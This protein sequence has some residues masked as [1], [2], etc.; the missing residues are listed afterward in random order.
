MKV[1]FCNLVNIW[2][3]YFDIDKDISLIKHKN[4]DESD[5]SVIIEQKHHFKTD[6]DNEKRAKARKQLSDVSDFK[7]ASDFITSKINAH[8]SY[9][10]TFIQ[11]QMQKW[12]TLKEKRN[13]ESELVDS[14]KTLEK[15]RDEASKAEEYD[16][17]EQ[18]QDKITK[19]VQKI[20]SIHRLTLN[21]E[22]QR[23]DLEN[24]IKEI[25]DLFIKEIKDDITM[26]IDVESK[27][28]TEK[29][30]YEKTE[31]EKIDDKKGKL[32]IK[33]IRIEETDKELEKKIKESTIKLKEIEEE[34][35]LNAKEHIEEKDK[36]EVEI[37]QVDSDI[38]E[39]EKQLKIKIDQKHILEEKHSA[40]VKAIRQVNLEFETEIED[41]NE[42]KEKY[43][44]KKLDNSEK[45]EA[46]EADKEKLK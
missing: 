1:R 3:F 9:I 23:S 21:L 37:Q 30:I 16:L 43:E 25:E 35:S 38:T 34:W 10:E 15:Q 8:Y 40:E 33:D 7:D 20:D 27:Q 12:R 26:L 17:A 24:Q 31:T 22:K 44:R 42:H 46:L 2:S 45:K 41:L 6:S 11:K 39:L 29:N 4:S 19:S 36:L 32:R 28:S 13:Q 5:E 14:I 18:L